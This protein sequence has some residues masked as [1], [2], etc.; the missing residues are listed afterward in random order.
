MGLYLVFYFV[1]PTVIAISIGLITAFIIKPGM[2]IIIADEQINELQKMDNEPGSISIH[3]IPN[4]IVD[5]IP[6][7]HY[8][9]W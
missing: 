2:Y 8:L 1:D 7:I 3:D 9:I 6:K 5:L 4:A